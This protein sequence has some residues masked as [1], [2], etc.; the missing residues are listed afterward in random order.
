MP[1]ALVVFVVIIAVTVVA[2]FL[3]K[4]AKE[5]ALQERA[6]AHA[7]ANVAGTILTAWLTPRVR[8]ISL[9]QIAPEEL[10]NVEFEGALTV[11]T[12][13]HLLVIAMAG[14]AAEAHEF[15]GGVRVLGAIRS[16][17]NAE[18]LTA[19]LLAAGAS[20]LPWSGLVAE[21]PDVFAPPPGIMVDPQ[22]LPLIHASFLQAEE[23]IVQNEQAF[24]RLM[25][26][27]LEKK[28]LE[29][30]ELAPLLG[31]MVPRRPQAP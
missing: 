23:L 6:A 14:L 20:S 1:I 29:E 3:L 13:Q 18:D 10:V 9:A 30:Q 22:A 15:D 31:I 16:W 11:E 2:M 8:A 19:Q 7:A 4:L 21:D 17:A 12:M 27:L 5:S 25:T 26:L 24:E 28:K